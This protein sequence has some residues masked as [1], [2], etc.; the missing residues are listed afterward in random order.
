[1]FSSRIPTVLC[2]FHH[3]CSAIER[4]DW[5]ISVSSFKIRSSHL[6][7]GITIVIHMINFQI[8]KKIKPLISGNSDG[9]RCKVI[10]D[11]GLPNIWGKA[12]IFYHTWGGLYSHMIL[13]PIRYEFPYI[14][15][16]FLFS[17]L[18]VYGLALSLV[19]PRKDGGESLPCPCRLLPVLWIIYLSKACLEEGWASQWRLRRRGKRRSRRRRSSRAPSPTPRK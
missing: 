10:Y 17:F 12:Q 14:L 5:I 3:Q 9:I 19:Y 13:H 7:N 2:W 6:R 8:K 16:K 1:M 4:M 15:G 11:D 18:S